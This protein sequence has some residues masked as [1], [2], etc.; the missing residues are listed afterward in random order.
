[1]VL[2]GCVTVTLE[3]RDVKESMTMDPDS[4]PLLIEPITWRVLS[5]FAEGTVILVLASEVYDPE[6]YIRD[7]AQF[8]VASGEC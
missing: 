5:D 3:R 6:D 2:R 4:A 1:M 8:L 7:Y